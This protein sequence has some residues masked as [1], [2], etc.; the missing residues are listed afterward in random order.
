MI[1]IAPS[2]LSADF[3]RL[4][5]EIKDVEKGGA[6]YIHVDVM[7]GHFV[8][9]ITIGPL[10]VEAIRPITSLP[11]DVHLMIENPDQYIETFAKAG[12]DIITVHV[13][14]CPHLH[15]TI[16]LIKSQGIKAGVV[17]NPHTPVSMIEHVLE[18]VDMVLFMTVNP[19]FGGQKFIHSVLPKIKQVA[20]VIR[21]RN[22]QVEI[23]VDGGVNVETAK[24]CVEAGAN[25]LVAGSAVYNEKDRG[26]AIAAIRG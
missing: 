25:V 7:D 9:N 12:A 20:D 24:L 4:G 21:E 11:L 5:E 18:D 13:E 19:G 10:I 1:K 14:A 26:A 3:S 6:D 2:I 17:L 15:R 8:P 22:L 23:E 16:Q